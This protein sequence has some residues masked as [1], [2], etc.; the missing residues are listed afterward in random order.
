MVLLVLT[1]V[2]GHYRDGN[3]PPLYQAHHLSVFNL[4]GD[5]WDYQAANRIH[6]ARTLFVQRYGFYQ[7]GIVNKEGQVA[8]FKLKDVNL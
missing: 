3:I 1:V 2:W 5:P 7:P 4:S 6:Y 8:F